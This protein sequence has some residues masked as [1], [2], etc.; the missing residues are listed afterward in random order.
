ME[1][2]RVRATCVRI[3]WLVDA[4]G[5][6][7]GTSYQTP[8]ELKWDEVWEPHMSGLVEPKYV[9]YGVV[10][11]V[12]WSRI[13]CESHIYVSGLVE[14]KYVV[15]RTHIVQVQEFATLW[16]LCQLSPTHGSQFTIHNC[17]LTIYSLYFTI[18]NSQ[19]TAHNVQFTFF[20]SQSTIH[21][22]WSLTSHT[23]LGWWL[24]AIVHSPIRADPT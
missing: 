9:V 1:C 5:P 24:I 3:S 13:E 20:N 8:L 10:C 2:W 18:Y 16:Q 4:L 23:T 12:W 19:L 17:R 15:G 21:N 6:S 14:P 22:C 7:L 11:G